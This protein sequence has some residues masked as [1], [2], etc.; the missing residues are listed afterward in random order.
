MGSA[1]YYMIGVLLMVI[2]VLAW[3]RMQ[4]GAQDAL[5][6]QQIIHMLITAAEQMLP[7]YTGEQKLEWVTAQL[8]QFGL[9]LDPRLERLMIESAV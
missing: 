2:V 7:G 4:P 9:N 5:E 8:K 3:L 1:G 6:P